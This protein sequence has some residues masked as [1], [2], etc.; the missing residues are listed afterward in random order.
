MVVDFT[1]G[2]MT[3]MKS[4]MNITTSVEEGTS[5]DD[6]EY[7]HGFEQAEFPTASEIRKV[8]TFTLTDPLK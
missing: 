3:M 4:N 8:Q 7:N 5:T 2:R 6:E 1:K